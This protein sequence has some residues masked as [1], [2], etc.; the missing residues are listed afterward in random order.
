MQVDLALR[1]PGLTPRGFQRLNLE[2]YVPLSNV[3]FKCRL[4]HYMKAVENINTILGPALLGK[5]GRCRLTPGAP[6]VSA[7]DPALAFNA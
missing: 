4:R 3:A 6:Q 7:V 5:V 1:A 2:Y